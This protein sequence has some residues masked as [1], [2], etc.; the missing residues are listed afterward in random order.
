MSTALSWLEKKWT[1][2]P[3]LIRWVLCWPLMIIG[4]ILGLFC[5]NIVLH[6]LA[7]WDGIEFSNPN[8]PHSPLA[9]IYTSFS[10]FA[11]VL[12]NYFLIEKLVPSRKDIV[13]MVF[14][15]IYWILASLSFFGI[16]LSYS[17]GELSTVHM[18]ANI[19]FTIIFLIAPIILAKKIV[20]R[21]ELF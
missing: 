14:V 16:F 19:A 13:A 6:I 21:E 18:L 7:W 3:A 2:S 5:L 4:I 10:V 8:K 11:M 12:L 9:F 1:N 15:G 17:D 20:L